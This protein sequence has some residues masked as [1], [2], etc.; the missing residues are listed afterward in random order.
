LEGSGGEIPVLWREKT[1]MPRRK[2]VAEASKKGEIPKTT[3]AG[4]EPKK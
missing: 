3:E 4:S 2:E 1:D